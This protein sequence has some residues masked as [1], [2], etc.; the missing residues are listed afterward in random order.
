MLILVRADLHA[1]SSSWGVISSNY[2]AGALSVGI[3]RRLRRVE[4]S[5]MVPIHP[6]MLDELTIPMMYFS[7]PEWGGQ[8]LLTLAHPRQ[9]RAIQELPHV[10]GVDMLRT[11]EVNA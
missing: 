3:E 4:R 9:R 10:I 8:L 2:T 11:V 6:E 1:F 7:P 5:V